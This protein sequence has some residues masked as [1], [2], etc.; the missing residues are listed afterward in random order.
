MPDTS[1]GPHQPASSPLP[2]I[3]GGMVSSQGEDETLVYLP[4]EDEIEINRVDPEII[5]VGSVSQVQTKAWLISQPL[6]IGLGE[7]GGIFES[8]EIQETE[9]EIRMRVEFEVEKTQF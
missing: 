6:D 7:G 4:F 5:E 2:A 3:P 8:T 1:G 9:F